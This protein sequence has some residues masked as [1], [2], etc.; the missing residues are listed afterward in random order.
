MKCTN[1][2]FESAFGYKYC[3]MCGTLLGR[4]CP[5]C[6]A[7]NPW[8]YLYCGACGKLL[9]ERA[10]QTPVRAAAENTAVPVVRDLVPPVAAA[11]EGERRVVTVLVADVTGSTN[12]LE[13]LGNETWVEMMNRVLL[14]L[15]A[16][17]YRY[18]G[19]VDQFRG[20]GLVAFFGSDISNEDDAE[21]AVLAGL[22]MQQA[23]IRFNDDVVVAKS[24]GIRLRVGINSGEVI[25]ASIGDK[26]QHREDTA[27]GIAI[28]VAARLETAAEPGSV[29]ASESVYQQAQTQFTWESLGAI[30]VKGFSQPIDVFRPTSVRQD[31]D[32]SFNVE[33]FGNQIPLVGRDQELTRLKQHVELL[34]MG[35]GSFVLLSGETGIGKQALITE[36]RQYFIRHEALIADS[37]RTGNPIRG[38]G[39]V[40]V[41][42]QPF[43]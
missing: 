2:G 13:Q 11:L 19:V 4:E 38:A 17:I 3:G 1:C 39:A 43:V 34:K 30:T 12:L 10:P 32:R 15:E 37:G 24:S 22:A 20:D 16:E 40:A 7:A 26:H 9:D 33:V 41:W 36:T 25:V 5:A 14:A 31:T 23:I 27:M 18:G 6:G 42:P 35:Q 29:L 21:R 28:A 8:E